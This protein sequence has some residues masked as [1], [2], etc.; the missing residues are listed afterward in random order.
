VDVPVTD[1]AVDRVSH[2]PV[3]RLP[4]APLGGKLAADVRE[5]AIDRW[6]YGLM[7]ALLIAGFLAAT[8]VY[9]T[10][11]HGGTDQNGYL[12][13]GKLFSR[14][15][16]NGFR[17]SDPFAFVGRMWIEGPDGRFFPKYPLGL[18]AIYA[19]TLKL[20][21][22][23]HGMLITFMVSPLAMTAALVATFLLAR[24]A[25]GSVAGV[26]AVLMLGSSSLTLNLTD[27]P[28]SHAAAVFCAA[29]G[30][31]FLLRWWQRDGLWRAIL[32]GL[33]LGMTMTIRYT[34]GL[35]LVPL[36]AV[37][38][39][40]LR[41][42]ERRSWIAS[43][44]L[45]ASWLVPVATLLIYNQASFHHLTGYDPTNESTGF[46]WKAVTENYEVLVRQLYDM[47]LFFVLPFALLGMVMLWRWNWRLALV[48]FLWV[49]P[50]L[51]TYAAYY[52]APDGT[53]IA[54]LRFFMTIMPALAVAAVWALRRMMQMAAVAE[55][56]TI[57]PM[58][59][60]GA[61]VALGCGISLSNGAEDQETASRTNHQLWDAGQSALHS[62]PAGSEIFGPDRYLNYFQLIGDWQLY[63]TQQFN[64]SYVQG[65][66]HVD[67]DAPNGLQPQRA[68]ETYNRLKNDSEA[69]LV[70]EQNKLMS[71]AMAE[72]RRVFILASRNNMGAATRFLPRGMFTSRIVGTWTDPPD[73]RPP[74]RRPWLG[75]NA[76]P[77]WN[78]GALRS[79]IWEIVE[80]LPAPPKPVAAAKPAVHRPPA[81]K[82]PP[83]ASPPLFS[84]SHSSPTT[85]PTTRPTN[86]GAAAVAH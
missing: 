82:A 55:G 23:R 7:A 45:V 10:P 9:W 49:V 37:A 24:L 63:D 78:A 27:N 85:L 83:T 38:L 11:A 14:T 12:V 81:V 86:A 41:W 25:A 52:W 3:D 67:P 69:D 54:Y 15:L 29:W 19:L 26:L 43:A 51:C 62:C 5:S 77:W 1:A 57:A 56:A 33:L 6:L 2:A 61:V 22:P 75:F 48:L 18:N 39:L 64:R 70:R 76:Q 59:G 36:V 20:G 58:I 53:S 4:R 34:E 40:N 50:T 65:L 66:A 30:I 47:G 80:V 28:N 8:H 44:V 73:V 42:R 71:A 68:K 17:P 13:G 21:G 32:A 35:L 60:I 72:R 31:Y 46:T 74:K 84:R 79:N 16:S